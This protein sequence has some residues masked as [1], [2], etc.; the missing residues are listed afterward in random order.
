MSQENS[1]FWKNSLVELFSEFQTTSQGLTNEEAKI[2]L[3]KYGANQLKPKKRI[4]AVALFL[5]QFKNPIIL[6]LFFSSILAF[7]LGDQLG[8]LIIIV[9]LLISSTLGFWQEYSAT[10]AIKK[11]IAMVQIQVAV[12]RD[13]EI[14]EV[15]LVEIVPGDCVELNAGDVVP[16]D[17]RIIESKD[18]FVNESTLTGE[19]FPV[20]K[21]EARLPPDTPL[22]KRTNSLFMGTHIV[23]GTGRALVVK[24]GL[25][26]EFGKISNRLTLRP[27]LTEF[28]RGIKRFGLMLME[29]TLLLV[30][31]I[32]A[33]NVYFARPFLDSFLFALALAVGITPQM[34]PA[35][36]SITLSQGAK[37]MAK[38]KVIVRRLNSIENFGSMNVLCT[39]KT[40]TITEGIIQIH[41]AVD[42]EGQK[43]EKVLQLAYLNAYFQSGYQNP[44]DDAIRSHHQFDL[45]GY[46]KLDE[47]PYDFIRKRL[48]I[49]VANYE[50]HMIVSKGAVP[51]ILAACANVDTK[52]GPV[53]IK[54]VQDQ[55]LK[56]FDEF[57]LQGLRTLGIAYRN[58]GSMSLIT[59]S[60]EEEMTFLG[61]LVLFD[62][63]KQTIETALTQM[64]GLGVS[65]KLI[66]GDNQFV[67]AN[68]G[69]QIGLDTARIITGS[70]LREMSDEALINIA[71]SVD[72]FAEIEPNQ[73]ERIILA[74]RKAGNVV[75]YMGDGI[76]DA[77]ALH[78]ADIGISVDGAVD[79]AKEAADIVLLEKD[80][81]VLVNGVRDGRKTFANTMKYV[82][83]TISANFGNMFSMAGASLFLPFLPL[84]PEQILTINLMTD[85]PS[86][87]IATDNVDSKMV[88]RPRRWN[89]KVIS[90][91][92]ATFGIWSTLFDFLTFGVLLLV[93]QASPDLFRTG[94][95]VISIIT[96]ILVLFVIRTQRF[97]LRSNPG[98]YLVIASFLV[99]V[100]TLI[101][102]YTPIGTLLGLIP[103]PVLTLVLLI[104][105]TA[106]YIFTTEVIKRFLFR[107]IQI[108]S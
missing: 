36:I 105:I 35:I 39:D 84:L 57:S 56:R 79:V 69:R 8:G 101:L 33:I 46:T 40:G 52:T 11:L 5:S 70:V 68:V 64:G 28:E 103:V 23:S 51:N 13:K 3:T 48:S 104:A 88:Q 102:P 73:K 15:S 14:Q 92:M 41:S 82:F 107:K 61:F 72:L 63:L 100:G 53:N 71:N 21:K 99:L 77:S 47:V 18:L 37:H 50:T 65:L 85:F 95:F 54:E 32:F 17:C 89:I 78:A 106:G 91:V 6:L 42:F 81:T 59:K 34:L 90:Q 44:I 1:N 75:G 96:E 43:N 108:Y 76:N 49:L 20:E 30:I 26:T 24:T 4:G 60:D 10:N 83:I 58:V 31:I 38:N 27:P 74:L 62:P 45:K 98:R 19:T 67:A 22:N 87:A 16:G 2:R 12:W 97:F 93:L 7:V 66:T 94:W 80:L 29:V 55:I 86:M 9:I 25:N